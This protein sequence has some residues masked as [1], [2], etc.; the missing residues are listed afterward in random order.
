M[1][2]Q[3][4]LKKEWLRCSGLD[5]SAEDRWV[6]DNIAA[7]FGAGGIWPAQL[8]GHSAQAAE[9]RLLHF[10]ACGR[11]PAFQV[12]DVR[13][14]QLAA[15]LKPLSNIGIR[16]FYPPWPVLKTAVAI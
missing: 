10:R 3:K 15:S 2:T 13:P 9:R 12:D 6:R 8:Y 5:S 14:P 11:R 1:R 4:E 7:L 16:P